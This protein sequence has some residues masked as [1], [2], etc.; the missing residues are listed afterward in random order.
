MAQDKNAHPRRRVLLVRGG[1][2]TRYSGLG[3]AFHD[4]RT[5]LEADQITGWEC[6]GVE[7]YNLAAGASGLRRLLKRWFGHPKQVLQ[8]IRRLHKASSINLIHVADQ[9]QAHLIPKHSP[10]PVVVYVHDFFHLFPET[11]SLNGEPIE[12]GEQRP[13]WYRRSDL[14]GLMKGINRANG[15]ICYT[16]AT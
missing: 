7:E 16:R 12:V 13:P 14:K 8:T 5:S 3:G 2:L 6:A 1:A 10:A 11:I 9:E 4:L 15:I